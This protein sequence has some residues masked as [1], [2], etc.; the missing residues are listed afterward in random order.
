MTRPFSV[1]SQPVLSPF[2]VPRSS[3]LSPFLSGTR[4]IGHPGRPEARKAPTGLGLLGPCSDPSRWQ[5]KVLLSAR[6]EAAHSAACTA[7]VNTL[8]AERL[9]S[10]IARDFPRADEG[11]IA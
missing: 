8:L 5:H 9:A 6:A 3:L 10:K 1:R 4:L 7:Q 2:S 11:R